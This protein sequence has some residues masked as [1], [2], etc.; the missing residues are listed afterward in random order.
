MQYVWYNVPKK[1]TQPI[2]KSMNH[3][4]LKEEQEGAEDINS[5]PKKGNNIALTVVKKPHKDTQVTV[6]EHNALQEM[7]GVV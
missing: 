2:F 4:C 1:Q 7:C 5:K 3:V 6:N